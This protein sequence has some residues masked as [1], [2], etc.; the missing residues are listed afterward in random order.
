M[1]IMKNVVVMTE[2]EFQ[3]AQVKMY[4]AAHGTK[5]IIFSKLPKEAQESISTAYAKYVEKLNAKPE[6]KP[7]KKS[8]GTK[9]EKKTE[10][11]EKKTK[12]PKAIKTG[13]REKSLPLAEREDIQAIINPY[14]D[15]YEYMIWKCNKN[16]VTLYYRERQ[17]IELLISNRT[18]RISTREEYKMPKCEVRNS[19]YKL[20]YT[21]QLKTPEELA[22]VLAEVAKKV[23]G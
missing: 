14:L 9:S 2:K 4:N 6:E 23:E 18:F 10:K 13:A 3:K 22:K 17:V 8:K 20:D 12:E 11:R 21:I 1:I 7:E 19:G 5:Y 15:R 16:L